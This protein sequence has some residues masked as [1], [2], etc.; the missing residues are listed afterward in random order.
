MLKM[1]CK[2]VLVVQLCLLVSCVVL[3]VFGLNVVCLS[4][5]VLLPVLCVCREQEETDGPPSVACNW[6]H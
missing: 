3:S 2:K 6:H 1:C 5:V 4:G